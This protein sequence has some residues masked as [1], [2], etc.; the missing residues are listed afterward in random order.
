MAA[1]PLQP[2]LVTVTRS[3]P[4]LQQIQETDG[5][6]NDLDDIDIEDDSELRAGQNGACP[7]PVPAVQLSFGAEP[8]AVNGEQLADI[9]KV[10]LRRHLTVDRPWR[11]LQCQRSSV[12]GKFGHGAPL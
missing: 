1:S 7:E 6:V 8:G 11:T 9:I 12:T 10:A 4:Q 2:F 5:Q 3:P